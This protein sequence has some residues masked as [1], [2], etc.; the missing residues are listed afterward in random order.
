MPVEV[1]DLRKGIPRATRHRKSALDDSKEWRYV[2][3][4]LSNGLKPHEGLKIVLTPELLHKVKNAA[5]L[6]KEKTEKYIEE[7]HL[8][9]DVFQRGTTSE[10]NPVIYVA[11]RDSNIA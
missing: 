11:D 5:R 8:N 4:K 9:Y 3:T 10:G 7:L 6:F 2:Q 1:I